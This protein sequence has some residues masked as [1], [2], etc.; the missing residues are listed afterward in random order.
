MSQNPSSF[1]YLHPGKN[2]IMILISLHLNGLDYHSWSRTMKRV[3]L[4]NKFKFVDG[5][6]KVP[7]HN[8]Y[9]YET[10]KRWN[11]LVISWNV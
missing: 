2:S 8:G 7:K 1:Y 5:S 3:I 11:V 9:L 6:I 4:K 10:W